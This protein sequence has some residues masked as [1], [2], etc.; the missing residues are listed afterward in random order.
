M[1][2]SEMNQEQ[3]DRAIE[4]AV[5]NYMGGIVDD[6]HTMR[7]AIVGESAAGNPGI[8]SRM[9]KTEKRVAVLI[10]MLPVWVT[11]GTGVGQYLVALWT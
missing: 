11:L 1:P 9:E 6:I 4:V 2:L 8:L 7:R 5:A 3:L 10:W